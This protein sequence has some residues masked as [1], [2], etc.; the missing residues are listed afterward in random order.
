MKIKLNQKV[1]IIAGNDK[2]KESV[3]TKIFKNGTVLVKDCKIHTKHQKP[4]QYLKTPG[5]LVKSE[6]P[7]NVSNL[8]IL[9]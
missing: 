9:I 5:G 4:N 1:K 6:S 2:G 3:I 7:I 8:E